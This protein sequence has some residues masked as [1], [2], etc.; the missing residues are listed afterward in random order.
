MRRDWLA[1]KA[2]A[3][4]DTRIRPQHERHQS[5]RRAMGP[6]TVSTRRM[7]APLAGVLSLIGGLSLLAGAPPANA[8]TETLGQRILNMAETRTGDWYVYGA[9]GPST[10]DCS[11]LVYWA[12]HQFGVNMPRTTY[13][14]VTTGVREG[15]LV[16]TYHPVR[17]DL[18]FFGPVGAP[19]HVEFVTVWSDTTFGALDTG[20][21]VGW[22]RYYPGSWAPSAFYT[23]R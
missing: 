22:H 15:I 4:S 9:A 21:Q 19:Y 3:T 20:T 2:G 5:V 13:E 14:M 18:A 12:S 7:I 23:I 11:G 10:F 1:R 16:R 8:S 6:Q 17:G